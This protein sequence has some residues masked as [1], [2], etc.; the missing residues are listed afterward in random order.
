MS[1]KSDDYDLDDF[2]DD[3]LPPLDPELDLDL[4]DD[5]LLE[6]PKKTGTQIVY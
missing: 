5:E 3:E 2:D 1:K 4:D 6:A